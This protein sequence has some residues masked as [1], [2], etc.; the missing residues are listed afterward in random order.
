MVTRTVGQRSQGATLRQSPRHA[1]CAEASSKQT[2]AVHKEKYPG[3]TSVMDEFHQQ[4]GRLMDVEQ[5]SRGLE[6]AL[7]QGGTAITHTQVARLLLILSEIDQCIAGFKNLPQEELS[8]VVLSA[9]AACGFTDPYEVRLV[10][11]TVLQAIEAN[12]DAPAVFPL[13]VSA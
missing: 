1:N 4:L 2:G 3:G 8:A 6:T 9:I 5:P 7:P 11:A 10:V 13:G 12:E